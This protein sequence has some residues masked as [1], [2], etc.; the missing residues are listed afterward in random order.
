MSDVS[1]HPLD[2]PRGT[3]AAINNARNAAWRARRYVEA[4]RADAVVGIAL[5]FVGLGALHADIPW[6]LNGP[7]L[8]LALTGVFL[9]YR[10]LWRYLRG[11]R[12]CAVRDADKDCHQAQPGRLVIRFLIS[13]AFVISGSVAFNVSRPLLGDDWYYG[14]M[15]WNLRLC[16][17]G[18]IVFF[19]Y[20]FMRVTFWEYLAF[21]VAIAGTC[22]LYVAAPSLLRTLSAGDKKFILSASLVL[23]ASAAVSLIKRRRRLDS[24]E[25]TEDIPRS[26]NLQELS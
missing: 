22:G 9:T 21:A 11:G 20:R 1:D 19:I 13:M 10:F 24:L 12:P 26:S 5:D 6:W 18:G 25:A 3:L 17:T 16:V 2:I 15:V 8:L 4:S 14:I 7:A 23:A